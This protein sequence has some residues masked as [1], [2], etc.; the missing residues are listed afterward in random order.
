MAE[1]VRR[2]S[3]LDGREHFEGEGISLSVAEPASRLSLRVPQ[4][5]VPALSK[6]LGLDLPVRP[7]GTAVAEKRAALWLGPDEWLVID[8][9]GTDL[10]ALRGEVTA[11]HSAVDVS[12]RNVGL[13]LSGARAADVLNA[14]C[15]LNLSLESFPVG[16]AS[17]TI[18]GKVEI[19]LWRRAAEAFHIEC[20]RSFGPYAFSFLEKAAREPE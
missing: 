11:L 5:S 1:T 6:A 9:S 14:G 10:A 7:K 19:V 4:G 18:F 3:P 8:E 12:H 2:V 15:P 17:R 13:L 16:A 20:W